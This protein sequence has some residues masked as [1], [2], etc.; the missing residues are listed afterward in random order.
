MRSDHHG[1]DWQGLA[2]APPREEVGAGDCQGDEPG[3]EH[4]S[5]VPAAGQGRAAPVPPPGGADQA[6]SL[7][8]AV[9]AVAASR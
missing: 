9:G 8:R 6:G 1:D 3:E 4:G 7:R 2:A 5:Q